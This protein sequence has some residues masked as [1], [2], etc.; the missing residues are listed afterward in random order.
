[1]NNL[2]GHWIQNTNKTRLILPISFKKLC[3]PFP[4]PPVLWDIELAS[5]NET[6]PMINKKIERSIA[7]KNNVF[8]MFLNSFRLIF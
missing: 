2:I 5:N 1:M 6:T 8:F 7:R 4:S 3:K